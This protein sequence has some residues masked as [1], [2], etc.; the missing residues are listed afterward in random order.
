MSYNSVEFVVSRVGEM[1][2]LY[3]REPSGGELVKVPHEKLPARDIDTV[4]VVLG[5]LGH[6][7]FNVSLLT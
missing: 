2:H 6:K 1:Y 3:R 5:S 4:M 7:D